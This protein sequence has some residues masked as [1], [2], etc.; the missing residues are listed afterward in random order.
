MPDSIEG[1]I[2]VADPEVIHPAS[3]YCVHGLNDFIQRLAPLDEPV[4]IYG[5]TGCGKEVAAR[6]LHEAGKRI[7]MLEDFFQFPDSRGFIGFVDAE[8]VNGVQIGLV[9][10]HVHK[11][12]NDWADFTIA[13]LDSS[14]K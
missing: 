9:S 13:T 2:A 7:G 11:N 3:Y 6:L 12:P 14:A 10:L 1:T 8:S 4:L 5:P